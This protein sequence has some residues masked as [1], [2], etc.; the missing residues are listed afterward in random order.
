MTTWQ[1]TINEEETLGV[2]EGLFDVPELTDTFNPFANIGVARFDD[3]D[4]ELYDKF[5]R[6]TRVDFEFAESLDPSPEEFNTR[7]EG[8][9][10]ERREIEDDGADVLEIEVYSLDQLLRGDKV[11]EDTSG[12]TVFEALETIIVN[13]TPVLWE[14]NNVSVGDN[15]TL[16][17]NLAGERAED[18]L[19]YLSFISNNEQISVN[20]EKEF[21]FVQQEL[22]QA[23]RDID[24]TQWFYAD[25]PEEGKEV[26]NEVRVWYDDGEQRV[27]V[28]S[29]ADK[30]AIQD[31]LGLDDTYSTVKE[32]P[33]PNI[34]D[35]DDAKTIGE[36]ILEDRAISTPIR[37]V[38]FGLEAAEPGQV[39]NVDI[40]S[41]GIE[42][43]DFQIASINYAWGADE[44]ELILVEN[45]GY[46]DDLLV[47]VVDAVERAGLEGINRDAGDNRITDTR[48]EAL[49]DV[50]GTLNGTS[51]DRTRFTNLGR[52]KLR[53]AW[54]GDLGSVEESDSGDV[55]NSSGIVYSDT[56]RASN[57]E[58][59]IS[60]TIPE[61]SSG[62]VIVRLLNDGETQVMD[63]DSDTTGDNV[64]SNIFASVDV[65]DVVFDGIEI[66]HS[67][68]DLANWEY[69][70][71]YN[72]GVEISEIAY[73]TDNSGL[74]RTNTELGNE[75]ARVAVSETL[76]GSKAVEYD[77][78][79]GDTSASEVGL[80][81]SDGDLIARAIT[82]S[83]Q[84]AADLSA[85]VSLTVSDNE[86]LEL[87]VVTNAGQETVRD[88][89]ADN[90]PDLTTQYAYGSD[91]TEPL[92]TD[93][94][95]GTELIKVDLEEILIQN[96]NLSVDFEDI[97][98]IGSENPVSI[99]GDT[100]GSSIVN[101][102]K[103]GENPDESDPGPFNVS[104]PDYSGGS[105]GRIDSTTGFYRWE[106][107]FSH[108]VPA[109][110]VGI[111]FRDEISGTTT[112]V[113]WSFNDVTL[114]I[115][116]GAGSIG[117]NWRDV[118]DGGFYDEGVGNGYTGED[119]VAG[120]TYI[121]EVAVDS[122]NASNYFFDVISVYDDRYGPY[123][124][125]N[126]VN[127]PD[128]YLDGPER[129]PELVEQEFELVQTK[130][131]VTEVTANSS[132]NDTSNSQFIE[133][134]NDGGT[135]TRT[136]NSET[137]SETF[138]ADNQVIANIGY[139][140]Y[141]ESANQTPIFGNNA[142]RMSL[143]EL[144]GNPS[145]INPSGLGITEVEAIA[146]PNEVVGNRLEESGQLDSA[147]N[148]LT[149]SVLAP[150]DVFEDVE[151]RSSEKTSFDN[152]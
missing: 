133:L 129:F 75:T 66:E 88:I 117:L 123:N 100:I 12:L 67:G 10:V 143:W 104:D 148:L 87:G 55:F 107:V 53:D 58:A 39:I 98:E 111:R 52:N 48:V 26:I 135:F 131:N 8:F 124:F 103:E 109:D 5:A 110:N 41:K 81:D 30:L 95:L 101:V 145:A 61:N 13:D 19:L 44:T 93:T 45:T 4:G 28:E 43:Q 80:F 47:R 78:S 70:V 144:F 99:E 62:T 138:D 119:L 128:G 92:V 83:D 3:R 152:R 34:T 32:V 9:V 147:D 149:R 137:A 37:V 69:N 64:T 85:L 22:E 40:P 151:I 29:G 60:M 105:A 120:E 102:V 121:L 14:P 71:S 68:E 89:L 65:S 42:A 140:R 33:R 15:V 132:W 6:G 46:Q 1:I 118:S 150:F 21:E 122:G 74:S 130:R 82:E 106:V 136:S 7:L 141:S 108:D 50:S 96:A 116:D 73:G 112:N 18:A 59:N 51:F 114:D 76:D 38:T 72:I 16:S 77:G 126:E 17:R 86:N 139:S 125:D 127:S 113:T 97:T 11:T 63:S 20:P 84:S 56:S 142:Q 25:V 54:G 27:T 91:G 36:Q 146:P 94:E 90:D 49:V 23:P 24:S 115:I 35:L 57:V 31:A 79:F 134:A 2:E